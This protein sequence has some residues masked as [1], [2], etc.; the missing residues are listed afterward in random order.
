MI[1]GD[2]AD[3]AAPSAVLGFP[4]RC[5]WPPGWRCRARGQRG[6][7]PAAAP[8]AAPSALR[9]PPRRRRPP[10]GVGR[11]GRPGAQGDRDG[12][13]LQRGELLARLEGAV[14]ATSRTSATAA[15]TPPGSSGS[16][17]GTCDMLELVEAYTATEPDNPLAPYLPALRAVD[18]SDSHEGLDPGFVDGV[19]AGR[20]RT[21]CSRR[22]RTTSATP[23]TSTP[24]VAAAPRR[25]GSDALGQFAYYDAAVMHGFDGDAGQLRR[26]RALA[27]GREDAGRGRRRDR[28]PR[29]RSSTSGWSR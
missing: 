3:R 11:S 16:A 29:R 26:I 27:T 14:R 13:G 19:A 10:T 21:R 7:R 6:A 8:T 20:R 23:S 18:G 12:A 1:G 24:S 9:R 22:P 17:R 2:L 5:R 25:T 28:L 15:A 4:S